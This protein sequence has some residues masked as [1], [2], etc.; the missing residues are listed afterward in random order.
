M[1]D[2]EV[3]GNPPE[4]Q[5]IPRLTHLD[6]QGHALM[7]DV[8]WKEETDRE[9]VAVGSVVMQP[10]TL[11]LIQAGGVEKGDVL[12]VARLAGIMGAKQTPHLIPLCHPIPLTKVSVD[13]ELDEPRSAVSITATARTTAPTVA[14]VAT[15]ATVT[16]AGA[17]TAH[18]TRAKAH[19]SGVCGI[20]IWNRSERSAASNG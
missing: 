5:A 15:V 9:A 16:T 20:T 6:Q 17:I 3:A 1:S 8:G 18:I 12:A 11:A 14:I 2:D 7:V 10:E 13:L 4:S 19:W